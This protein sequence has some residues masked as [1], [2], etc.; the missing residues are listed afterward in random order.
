[1][2][3]ELKYKTEEAREIEGATILNIEDHEDFPEVEPELPGFS[4]KLSVAKRIA[5][6]LVDLARNGPFYEKKVT[7]VPQPFGY[8][9]LRTMYVG[10]ENDL[11]AVIEQNGLEGTGHVKD[12]PR[13]TELGKILRRT[14]LDEIPG[15]LSV[16]KGDIELVGPR[17]ITPIDEEHLPQEYCEAIRGRYGWLPPSGIRPGKKTQEMRVK[18]DLAFLKLL[19]KHPDKKAEI[20]AYYAPVIIF[21]YLTK[22]VR[23]E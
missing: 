20:M 17:P 16:T 15:I 11:H 1:M 22:R 21:N 4:Y 23:N 19:D 13:V 10:A 7:Q 9:K 6:D 18:E 12:D 8:K 5:L 14:S 2:T 3:Q